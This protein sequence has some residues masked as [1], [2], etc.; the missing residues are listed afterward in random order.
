MRSVVLSGFMATGKSTL[1]GRLAAR[2]GLAFVDSDLE[3]ERVTGKSV[4]ELWRADGEAA[5]R[6]REVDVLGPLLLDSTPRV[7]AFGGGSVTTRSLRHLALDHAFVVTLTADPG[8]IVTR[9]GNLASRPNL[10]AGDPLQRAKDLLEARA[11]AYAECHLSLSTEGADLDDLV[12]RI[13]KARARDPIAVPL[14]QRSYT[15]E[16]AQAEPSCLT[17]RRRSFLRRP[18]G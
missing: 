15:V 17:E 5:F 14:G 4:A 3:I 10:T 7:I 18:E 11:A 1:G 16:I 8:T 9:A 2:L 13:A 12:E 6:A